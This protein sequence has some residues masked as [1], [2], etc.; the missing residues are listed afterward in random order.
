MITEKADV[1]PYILLEFG[2]GRADSPA[3]I[4]R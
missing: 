4:D 3:V 2:E 1:S